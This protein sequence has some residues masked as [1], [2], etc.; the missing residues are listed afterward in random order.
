MREIIK[1]YNF[2]FFYQW[3]LKKKNSKTTTS[4]KV[5]FIHKT[6]GMECRIF[7]FNLLLWD[8]QKKNICICCMY[9]FFF[10]CNCMGLK[11]GKEI[12]IFTHVHWTC[13]CVRNAD[14]TFTYINIYEER[15]KNHWK[16]ILVLLFLLQPHDVYFKRWFYL[17]ADFFPASYFWFILY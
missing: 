3:N 7:F 10:R 13:A 15:K 6:S 8:A 2:N 1:K 5:F 14:E 17:T 11:R 12:S 9:D 16:L 4:S